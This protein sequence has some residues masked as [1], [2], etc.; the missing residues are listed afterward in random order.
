MCVRVVP[1]FLLAS[2][3]A[4]HSAPSRRA[5]PITNET[6]AAATFAALPQ[7]PDDPAISAAVRTSYA[8]YLA[9]A[10]AEVEG[11]FTAY[12]RLEKSKGEPLHFETSWCGPQSTDGDYHEPNLSDSAAVATAR[13]VAGYAISFHRAGYPTAVY[14][15]PLRE[16]QRQ[17]LKDFVFDPANSVLVEKP[18]RE[19]ALYGRPDPATVLTDEL[20]RRRKAISP[21]LPPLKSTY[22]CGVETVQ[23]QFTT[24]P[25]GG[26]VYL[27][28]RFS[29]ELC[30]RTTR[31][32]FDKAQCRRWVEASSDSDQTFGNYVVQGRW[33][34]GKFG[35]SDMRFVPTGKE[36]F[37]V[38]KVV[39]RPN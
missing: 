20:E 18:G 34:D 16:Y 7:P 24:D 28:N 3:V 25:A 17:E 22:E 26:R 35:W 39:V 10:Q 23:V 1:V 15:E 14:V 8:A 21:S 33:P 37:A 38:Q 13:T 4:C 31:D 29:F 11:N 30:R 36:G 9:A 27:A 19:E 32:P 5:E 6:E 12:N 2:M